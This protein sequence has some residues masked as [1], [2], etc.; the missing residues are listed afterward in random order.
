MP[1][2]GGGVIHPTQL[3]MCE[4]DGDNDEKFEKALT[5]W[6]F[7]FPDIT[8]SLWQRFSFRKKGPLMHHGSIY[9]VSVIN[10]YDS[11]T[12]LCSVFVTWLLT[13]Q[14]LQGNPYARQ[15]CTICLFKV[16]YTHTKLM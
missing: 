10:S 14:T 6:S 3:T 15:V 8:G 4:I 1:Y 9:S 16:K 13:I 11:I 2:L 7:C 12:H 5:I